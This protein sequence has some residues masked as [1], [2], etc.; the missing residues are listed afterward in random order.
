M[1]IF[2]LVSPQLLILDDLNMMVIASGN[3]F[4]NF[5][6][7]HLQALANKSDNTLATDEV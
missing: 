2:F 3:A 1:T 5:L 4:M 7:G 6:Q